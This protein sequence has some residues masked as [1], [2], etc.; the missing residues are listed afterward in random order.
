M[1]KIK[2]PFKYSIQT[3]YF[4][5]NHFKFFEKMNSPTKLLHPNTLLEQEQCIL[6]L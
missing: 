5:M 1:L 6:T 2:Y 4:I 3:S